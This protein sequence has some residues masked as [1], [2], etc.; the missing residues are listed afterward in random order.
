M[1][2]SILLHH[3]ISKLPRNLLPQVS[4]FLASYQVMF[5]MQHIMSSFLKFNSYLL[6][7]RAFS[8]NAPFCH[9]NPVF[10]FKCNIRNVSNGN[11]M[12]CLCINV[13]QR[14]KLNNILICTSI[15]LYHIRVKILLKPIT[16]KI[17]FRFVGPICYDIISPWSK[18]WYSTSL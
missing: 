2:F 4:K 5:H 16:I 1:F 7:R 18:F 15:T 14:H 10:R 9:G 13:F 8:L 6:V 12:K 3:H 11:E 17:F